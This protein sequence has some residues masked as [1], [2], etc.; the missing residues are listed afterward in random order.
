MFST[1]FG[2]VAKVG[3]AVVT[4]GVVLVFGW[5]NKFERIDSALFYDGANVW[6]WGR[7]TALVYGVFPS[8]WEYKHYFMVVYPVGQGTQPPL[9][10]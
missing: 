2:Y 1:G 8:F 4:V 3:N 7:F 9:D 10:I 6:L 5:R